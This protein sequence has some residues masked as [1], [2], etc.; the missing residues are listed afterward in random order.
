MSS[1][2]TTQ[3]EF[4]PFADGPIKQIVPATESQIE[5]W[6]SVQLGDDANCAFNES[7][8]LNLKGT[9]DN[10]AITQAIEQLISRH[11]GLR[12]TFSPDG[13]TLIISTQPKFDLME[14]D[15]SS[16]TKDER[17]QEVTRLERMTAQT[18][19]DLEHGP[20]LRVS[21]IKTEQDN[22]ILLITS[23]HIVCDGWSIWVILEELGI[24]YTAR[25]SNTYAELQTPYQFT[26]YA[27]LQHE[28]MHG[29]VWEKDEAYWVDNFTPP[30]LPL[31]I[32]TTYKR[33]P[34]RSF[35][36]AR[37]DYTFPAQLVSAVKSYAVAEKT[38][39]TTV[40]LSA[41]SV[42]LSRIGRQDDPIIGIP[43]AGQAIT[44]HHYL[45]GHCVNLL[46]MRCTLRSTDTFE[47]YL[48]RYK[49]S[50]LDAYDHQ[51]YTYGS[52]LKKIDLPR[53]TGRPPLVTVLFNIDQ[54]LGNVTYGDLE[55][56]YYTPQ[57]VFENFEMFLNAS[58]VQ[59]ELRIECQYNTD[60]FSDKT[61]TYRLQEFEFFLEQL[62]AA[63]GQSLKQV[64]LIPTVENQT[65][66]QW[67]SNTKDLPNDCI[68]TLV[69]KQVE[70]NPDKEAILFGDTSITYKDLN[71]RA[72][73][74]AGKLHDE[75]IT[76]GGLIG[77]FLPRSIDM[78]VAMLAVLKTGSAYVPLDPNYPDQRISYMIE[79]SAM[80]LVLT[81]SSLKKSLPNDT[82]S[83]FCVESL[84]PGHEP[85]DNPTGKSTPDDL[86]YVIYTSG[87]TGQPKG[88]QVH[89][90]AVVNFLTSMRE[91]PGIESSDVLVALTTLSFDIAGL[92]IFLPL[93]AGATVALASTEEASDGYL[94]KQLM[95]STQTTMV[96][97][98]PATYHML[99]ASEWQG[100][101][102]LK[103]LCG[104]ESL[105]GTLAKKLLPC[106]AELWNM[107]GPT[108]TTVW[109]TCFRVEDADQA[110][111]IGK[112]IHNTTIYL[113]DENLQQAPVGIPA[114]L[115][116]GGEG[117]S[118]GYLDREDLTKKQFITNPIEGFENETIYRTGDLVRLREDGNL[119]YFNRFDNQVKIRGFRIELGEIETALESFSSIERAAVVVIETALGDSRLA[120][121]YLASKLVSNQELRIH[122]RTLLPEYMIP[123]HIVQLEHFPLTPAGKID[124]KSLPDPLDVEKA[125]R[126]DENSDRPET[127]VE[128]QIFEIWSEL[129]G[130]KEILLDDN[131]FDLGGHSLL[132]TQAIAQIKRALPVN[133]SL[134][135]FFENPSIRMLSAL[136]DGN[137]ATDTQQADLIIPRRPDQGFAVMSLQQQRLW[138]LDKL[139]SQATVYNLPAAFR[140]FG[141]FDRAVFANCIDTIFNRHETLRTAIEEKDGGAVQVI[142][143]D[144]NFD[145][146]FID[147]SPLTTDEKEEKLNQSFVQQTTEVYTLSD[148]PLFK[149]MLYKLEEKHHVFFFMPHHAIWDG[150]S[151]D[152]FLNELRL[153]YEGKINKREPELPVLPIQYADFAE[154]QVQRSN[155]GDLDKQ[156]AYWQQQLSDELPVLDLNTDFPRP[157]IAN[158]SH[159]DSESMSI[160][161]ETIDAL[162]IIGRREDVT[163]FMMLFAIFNVFL[164]KYTGGQRDIIVG[165]PISGRNNAETA[166]LLG[167]FVN[168]L[169]LRSNVTS[170]ERF[171]S[172]LQQVKEMCL[173]AFSN[174]EAPF[175]KIIER[176]NPVRDLSRSPIFQVMFNF[177]DTRNRKS[178]IANLELQQINVSRSGVQTD[179]DFWVRY[180][181]N[182]LAG[183]FEYN[184]DL[185]EAKTI[186][187]MHQQY[188][189]ILN[190][191][192]KKP[193]ATIQEISVLPEDENNKIINTW[194]DT[195][196]P[197][198][199]D[200]SLHQFISKQVQVTPDAI[201]VIYKN[202]QYS[203]HELEK[204]SNQ[205]A[206]FLIQSGVKQGELVGICVERSAEMV[207]CLLAVLKAG[208]AY[209]PLDPNYPKARL[210]YMISD[211][212]MSILLT[213]EKFANDFA[214]YD[215]T[216]IC[217]D[218][219]GPDISSCPSD[220]PIVNGTP[221]DL[222]YVIYTS[223]S[224]GEPKGVEVHHRAVVNFLN[225]MAK[226]PGISADDTLLAVTTLS[227]D[228]AVLEV[229]LPLTQGAATYI[230]DQDSATDGEV[231]KQKIEESGATIMQATPGTWRL[232][233]ASEW[234]GSEK[235]KILC[236]GEPF[237]KD[238]VKELIKRA[239]SVWNMYGPTETTVWSTCHRL[240]GSEDTIMVGKPID[241]TQIYILDD[242][243]QPTPIGVPGELYIGG[244][245]VTK[246]YHNRADLTAKHFIAN[247]FSDNDAALLYRT[248]DLARYNE[249]GNIEHLN[250][251]DN[252]V[253][254]RGFRIEL[255]EIE[256]VLSTHNS[257]TQ[258]VASVKEFRPGDQRLVAYLVLHPGSAITITEIRE[259]LGT[260]L[261]GYM[262]PQ[263]VVELDEL[264]LTPAGK[265]D[266]KSLPEPFSMNVSTKEDYIAPRT[267]IEKQL[268]EIWKDLLHLER[269]GINDNF[270]E[271]GGHSLLSVQ[272]VAQFKKL[273]GITIS[274]RTILLNTLEQIA[275]QIEAE[276]ETIEVEQ[277][278]VDGMDREQGTSVR[279][280]VLGR[281]TGLLKK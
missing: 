83:Q 127:K 30:P 143:E 199:N 257:I 200:F 71:Q 122:L 281:L 101:P 237:P 92:E 178:K 189:S 33:P 73:I 41:F 261:P 28:R 140:M 160:P 147:L 175:E 213:Q 144:F 192:I 78:V 72:N 145:L 184:S 63:P 252:Q 162:R 164:Y 81:S 155:S 52:L 74:L 219:R 4:D 96:Q 38:T 48:E 221:D 106:C 159:A 148:R 204:H 118:K 105:P 260:K 151:F 157:A 242:H 170:N 235:L 23:H 45:I 114:E 51:Q 15:L 232:L 228:I 121:F 166:N 253:K 13:Q 167:F 133:I 218:S 207:V 16:L 194:N 141:D 168:T 138:Y 191:I 89:H 188:V 9:L 225:S 37:K 249:D 6:T 239:G 161:K 87:S 215:A 26:S 240:T 262:I 264:P 86:A 111:L 68:H 171:C 115:C 47:S 195:A 251:I 14:Y 267:E 129:L 149:A 90:R 65:F 1:L 10:T 25:S 271:I 241:N 229:F 181:D 243:M 211:T 99:L 108:E 102:D 107:Y 98:T 258:V 185:F 126:T 196:A 268:A 187:R 44:G 236:G 246:G 40:L 34:M 42:F 80:A 119:E 179:I 120:A 202:K 43:A 234:Q 135:Q 88:V 123:Q 67:N 46:P 182:G 186:K 263:H 265:I 183:G 214:E 64:P 82:V 217:F 154:W 180:S 276:I 20:L 205:L 169:V 112:P 220:A 39:L 59:G 79:N 277:T 69:E 61:I 31:D 116:I 233:I 60:L 210:A 203:Y 230:L 279:K 77:L 93:I 278:A 84:S 113:L 76:N 11:E 5:I 201:A 134:R 224:T 3:V 57:R 190:A 226:K 150:W 104:G 245:G 125:S 58:E 280:G 156:L 142:V 163:L 27:N 75:G 158:Y 19:F 132:A 55:V 97:A 222:A 7:I 8:A 254:V 32:P 17:K 85:V 117:V 153:L 197:Y 128:K 152:I 91:C 208:A 24:L 206:N 137:E 177:Q 70:L 18:P 273:T 29:E 62:L 266:R 35:R 259:H 56:E 94:L 21:L 247:P 109:S 212:E 274:L 54:G 231:L 269:V 50:M 198:P 131:F 216:I 275:N 139:D 270:L 250:R 272:V 244:A 172:L 124:R 209:V 136:C 248:G 255:G 193:D 130:H 238:L 12:T 22:H 103:I 173:S 2:S 49:Q 176:I 165:T 66:I 36:A 95:S 256:S 227:F 100:S 146:P 53:D 174:Q 110:I 223:G